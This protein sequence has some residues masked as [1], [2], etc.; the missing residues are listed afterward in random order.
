MIGY[1]VFYNCTSLTSIVIPD[2]VSNIGR[3]VFHSCTSLTSIVI[4]DSVSNIGSDVFHSCTSLT[5][6]VIPDS[7]STIGRGVFY[8]CTSL[9]SIVIPDLTAI[10]LSVFNGC[11]KLTTITAPSFSTTTFGN[12]PDELEDLLINAGFHHINLDTVLYGGDD[13]CSSSNGYV[14]D[15]Y[16]NMKAWGR[17]EDED[18]GRLPLFIAAAR[19]LTW[20]DMQQIFSVNMSA[21]HEV[22]GMTGLPVFMLAAAGPTSDIEA[23]YNL[24]REYPPAIV[25]LIRDSHPNTSIDTARTYFCSIEFLWESIWNCSQ[26]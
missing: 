25:G 21:I 5:S 4:P 3:D 6:I 10:S 18:S 22:D 20:V 11:S 14:S 19:C 7:V 17:G 13:S 24:L 2:S 16:Y 26:C 12:S 8:N 15:I 1:H 9:I 23:V